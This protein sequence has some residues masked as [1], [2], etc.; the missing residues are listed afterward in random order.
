MD[1][2]SCGIRHGRSSHPLWLTGGLTR[3]SLARRSADAPFCGERLVAFVAA[4]FHVE[5]AS[6]QAPWT[7][8]SRSQ[9]L[10]PID[11]APR[12]LQAAP[13]VL[14][15]FHVERRRNRAAWSG[16]GQKALRTRKRPPPP[17]G[18]AAPAH[19][20]LAHPCPASDL[21]PAPPLAFHVERFS[22]PLASDEPHD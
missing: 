20:S 10:A 17:G 16:A 21:P 13:W 14:A 2:L 4:P 3:R 19:P 22:I 1:H 11:R 12:V 7:A 5:Q 8:S 9:V 6:P 15:A 18:N